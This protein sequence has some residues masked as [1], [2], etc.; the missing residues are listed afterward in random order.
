MFAHD[1]DENPPDVALRQLLRQM[2]KEKLELSP[3][4]KEAYE[5]ACASFPGGRRPTL[6]RKRPLLEEYSDYIEIPRS[7]IEG[8]GG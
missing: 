8:E 1:W 7:L 3:D 2:E 4:M 6:T 5:T